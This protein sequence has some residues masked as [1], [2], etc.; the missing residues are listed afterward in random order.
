M[1]HPVVRTVKK[2]H[3]VARARYYDSPC[4][5]DG[6]VG[7]EA[8]YVPVLQADGHD[9]LTLAILHDQVC[10]E[11]LDEVVGVVHQGLL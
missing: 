5:E 8:V 11:V 7:P 6:V 1:T 2:T 3:P 10:G 4:S 9:A